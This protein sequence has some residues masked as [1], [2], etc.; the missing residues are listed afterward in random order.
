MNKIE[1]AVFKL[2]ETRKIT[3]EAHDPLME[4]DCCYE[5]DLIFK[6]SEQSLILSDD[7]IRIS[8]QLLILLL[9][10][11]LKNELS[12][13][14]SIIQDVGF[15]YNQYCHFL[16]SEEELSVADNFLYEDGDKNKDWI[17]MRYHLWA[18]G[19]NV[20]WLYN[21]KSGAIILEVTPFY[22]YLHVDPNEEPKYVFYGEWIKDYKPYFITTIPKETAQQW[23]EQAESVVKQISDNVERWEKEEKIKGNS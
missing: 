5:G 23:L 18:G 15:I 2:D 17:G 3:L 14:R 13:D 22:P 1:L 8:M 11:V 19:N 4:I 7:V 20:T 10:R 16:W 6:Q 9:K 12:L 21:D